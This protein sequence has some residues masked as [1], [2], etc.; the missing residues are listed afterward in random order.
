[1]LTANAEKAHLRATLLDARMALSTAERAE[2]D[3]SLCDILSASPLLLEADTVFLYAAVRGEIDLTALAETLSKRGVALAYPRTE[4]GGVMQFHRVPTCRLVTGR[5]GIPEPRESEPIARHTGRSVCLVPAL[6]YDRYGYRLG[7]GGGY[8]DR[9]LKGFSGI[10]IGIA[11]TPVDFSIPREAH[12]L[13]V[14]YL[15]GRDGILRPI[16]PCK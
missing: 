13:A 7:Y 11:D 9:F 6:A 10:S 2:R 14:D 16:P 12:D 4:R 3:A 5:Y 1:M 15:V 8:Y